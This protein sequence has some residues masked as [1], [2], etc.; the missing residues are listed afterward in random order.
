[1]LGGRRRQLS[2]NLPRSRYADSDVQNWVEQ[3]MFRLRSESWT[4][5]RPPERK[6]PDVLAV[7]GTLYWVGPRFRKRSMIGLSLQSEANMR[8]SDHM[9]PLT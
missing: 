7:D 4:A 9:L 8:V 1:M 2:K 3:L 6:D 5:R